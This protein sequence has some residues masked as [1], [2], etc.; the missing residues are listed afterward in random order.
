MSESDDAQREIYREHADAYDRLVRAE[1]V[2]G[3]LARAIGEIVD[4]RGARVLDVGC[5]TGR[6]TRILLELGAAHVTGVDRAEAMLGVA[7]R[8]LAAELA[9]GAIELVEADARALAAHGVPVGAFDVVTAG[10]CFGHFRHWMPDDWREDVDRALD[11]MSRAVRP[12]GVLIVIETLGTGHETP[13]VHAA[14]DEYFALLE[15]RGFTRRAIRTDYAFASVE[16]AVEV[17]GPFFGEEL[18]ARIVEERWARVPECTGV[19]S[20]SA[21]APGV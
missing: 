15:A 10:W 6:L 19:W 18:S 11:A 4:V 9:R 13:R 20:R 12:G 7:A 8:S 16:E 21:S 3:Q 17:L 2:D 14:L 1:D 5:G